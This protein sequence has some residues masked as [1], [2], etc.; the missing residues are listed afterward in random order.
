MLAQLRV[1]SILKRTQGFEDIGQDLEQMI[2]DVVPD[3]DL[4]GL[5]L[6]PPPPIYPTQTPPFPLPKAPAQPPP[7]LAQLRLSL[8]R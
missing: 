1:Q 7:V 6:K 4:P 5:F 2:V 8:A 3:V